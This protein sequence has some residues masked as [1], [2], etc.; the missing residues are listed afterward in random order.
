MFCLW[1]CL[2]WTQGILDIP[3]YDLLVKLHAQNLIQEWFQLGIKVRRKGF[4]YTLSVF[5]SV[6]F[7]SS[8]V[9]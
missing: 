6:G 3:L 9:I 4:S 1:V 8:L 5:F 7:S 2:N